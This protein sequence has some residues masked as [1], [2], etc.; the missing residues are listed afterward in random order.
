MPQNQKG[1]LQIDRGGRRRIKDRRFR[2]SI[3]T[4]GTEDINSLILSVQLT[5]VGDQL[6][7]ARPDVCSLLQHSFLHRILFKTSINLGRLP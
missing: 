4:D 3:V 5:G 6:I 2:V 1:N 7:P